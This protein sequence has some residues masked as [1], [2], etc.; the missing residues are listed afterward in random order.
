MR[1][2]KL[3][4]Y[5]NGLPA[6]TREFVVLAGFGPDHNLGVFNNNIDNLERAFAERYFLC[7]ENGEFRPALPVLRPYSGRLYDFRELV[8]K[9]MRK[10]PRLSRQQVVDR[11]TGRKRQVYQNA[12]ESLA[13]NE[14]TH[15]DSRLNA[16]T[17]FEKQDTSKAPRVINP[18]TARYNLILGTYLKHAEKP[19]FSAIN[20]AFGAR[21]P[22]TVI[23]GFNADDSASILLQKWRRFCNPVAVGLD[24]SKFDMHVSREALQYEHSFYRR[25]F[26]GKI[27]TVLRQLLTWQERNTGHAH[28]PDG[29]VDFTMRAT[30]A[31]GDLNTSLG[32]CIIMCALIHAFAAQRGIEVEL[33]NNGDDCVVFMAGADLERFLLNLDGWFRNYGFAMV[34]ETPV[35]EFEQ[36]EFCQTHPVEL[37]TGWRMIRNHHAVLKKDPMC[38]V[39]VQNHRTFQKWLHAVGTGGSHIA[40]GCPVQASFYGAFKRHGVESSAGFQQQVYANSSMWERTHGLRTGECAVSATARVSY[41]YAFG[42]TPDEQVELEK[43]YAGAE[44]AQLGEDRIDRVHLTLEPG[45]ISLLQ[46]VQE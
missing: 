36:V 27:G 20:K 45:L 24:A 1:G 18:R 43:Y 14:L 22:A 21:T 11:Y 34:A 19:F 3:C 12:L 35:W 38:L 37:A 5:R 29:R 23:K 15:R 32:N 39:A 31:S 33:A 13:M 30:R 26:P 6:K 8:M 40:A 41:C 9:T 10:L 28:V 46:N 7:S 2:C 25:L 17:K 42:V 16:F 44:L 4:A